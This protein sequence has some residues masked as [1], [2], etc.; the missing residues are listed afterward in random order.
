MPTERIAT[1][2]PVGTVIG[3]DEVMLLS[4][5][6]KQCWLRLRTAERWQPR[7]EALHVTRKTFRQVPRV[8]GRPEQWKN[9]PFAIEVDPV[10]GGDGFVVLGQRTE[11]T[12]EILEPE[13]SAMHLMQGGQGVADSS[14]VVGCPILRRALG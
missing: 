10:V 5:A 6:V 3:A 9:T 1:K 7:N 11:E 2:A 12:I 14:P 13:P 4:V 8:N